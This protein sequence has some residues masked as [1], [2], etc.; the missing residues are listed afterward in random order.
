MLYLKRGQCGI[1]RILTLY[2]EKMLKRNQNNM[3]SPIR[4][5]TIRVHG[6]NLDV[7][8]AAFPNGRI[9]ISLVHRGAPYARVSVNVPAATLESNMFLAKDYEENAPLRGPLLDSGLFADTGVR[10][11]VGF[12]ELELW[13]LVDG[14]VDTAVAITLH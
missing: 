1:E 6:M 4:I 2:G 11:Q 9:A 10:V 7:I 14:P 3:D 13:R 12:V 5:G 8:Q